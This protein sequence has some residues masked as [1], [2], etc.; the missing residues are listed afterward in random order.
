MITLDSIDAALHSIKVS[1]GSNDLLIDASGH[2]SINDGG[3][4]LTVDAV[5][6]DIRDLDASQDNVAISDGTDTL[7]VNADGSINSVVTAT[8]LDIRDLTHASDSIKV[9]DGTD[10]LEVNADGSI[11]VQ[12]FE[13]GYSSWKATAE[14]VTTTAAQI[15]STPLSSRLRMI[16]QNLGTQDIYLGQVVGVTT[17]T[18]LKLPKGSS[19]EMA[20]DAGADIYALTASS[21]AD[22]RISEFAA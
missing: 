6:L 3:N 19:I 14:S 1:D 2:I 17:S 7:A 15:A 13:G 5:D 12:S 18:G 4:S 16:I 11:N 20:W 9:G 21:T 10:F 8:D 22:I